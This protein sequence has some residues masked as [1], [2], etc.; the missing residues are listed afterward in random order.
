[1]IGF[2]LSG[3]VHYNLGD[4]EVAMVFFMLMGIGTKIGS[5]ES[6]ESFESVGS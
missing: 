6:G 2:F 1:M 3:F 4:Q 5:F